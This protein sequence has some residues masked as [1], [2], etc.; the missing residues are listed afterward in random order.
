MKDKIKE[1]KEKIKC[2]E[3]D[4]TCYLEELKQEIEQLKQ[5]ES[6]G[7]WIPEQEETYFSID[8]CGEVL[9][10]EW[11]NKDCHFYALYQHNIF[12]TRKE[13]ERYNR[14]D[15][16]FKKLVFEENQ[17]N[18]IDWGDKEQAKYYIGV[19]WNSEY[20]SC[21]P[22]YIDK[23]QS[24]TYCTNP[25]ILSLTVDLIGEEDLIWYIKRS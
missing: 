3:K 6:K 15:K 5:K 21:V 18:P 14:I 12:K 20:L 1:L 25:S 17:K 11:Y 4:F 13:V 24:I 9:V 16:A 22:T 19:H 23:S 2:L 10:Y 8:D 7:V